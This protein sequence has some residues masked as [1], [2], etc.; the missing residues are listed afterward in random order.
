MSISTERFKQR[1]I[2]LKECFHPAAME[3]YW[4]KIVKDG[5]RKQELLD[6]HDYYDFHV[7]RKTLIPIIRAQI[8][9]GVYAP[10][11]PQIIRKEKK[12]GVCRHMQI[13]SPDDALVLQTLVEKLAPTILKA[14]PSQRAYYSRSHSAPKSESDVDDKFSYEWWKL[15]PEFQERIYE[16]SKAFDYVV[17]T[18]IANYYD[19][20]SF[21]G[22]RNVISSYGNFDEELLDFLFF[23]LESFVWRP[24]YLTLS[25]FGLPQVNFDAP[26][27]LGHSFLFEIDQYLSQSTNENFVRWM[28]DIDFGVNDISE[29][30]KIL[31]DLDEL[32]LTR[33][34]RLN[35]GK[36]KILSSQDARRYF[37]VEENRYLTILDKRIQKKKEQKEGMEYERKKAENKIHEIY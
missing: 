5:M 14:Q 31:R 28:D 24:D 23:M 33:G 8:I 21:A 18:D 4:Q 10:K 1:I 7:N 29:G 36:T 9:N 2:T 3:S 11:L 20:I 17:V 12:Y 22:L 26:R 25:G 16:F 15:W 35:M 13:P 27:L 37:M 6:L 30:K 32:L 34:L 19:N